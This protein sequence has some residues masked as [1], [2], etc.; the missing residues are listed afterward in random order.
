MCLLFALL[1]SVLMLGLCKLAIHV[2][3]GTL[4]LF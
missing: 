1:V 4:V 3:L 2:Y